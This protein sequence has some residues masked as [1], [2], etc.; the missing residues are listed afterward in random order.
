MKRDYV[1]S[2][3]RQGDI[4]AWMALAEEVSDNFPGFCAEE[5]ERTLRKNILRG[6]AICVKLGG[7]MAGVLLYSIKAKC[8]SCMA[9]SPR[10]RQ[11]GVGSMLVEKMIELFPQGGE[12][13]GTTFRE[14]DPLGAAP[15]ALYKKFGF[16]ESELIMEHGYPVQKLV[17]NQSTASKECII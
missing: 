11:K 12:A 14:D 2:M 10:H 17:R 16:V 15:R 9:V 7:E 6:S 3:A 1:M 8:L 4:P 13:W 5:Y